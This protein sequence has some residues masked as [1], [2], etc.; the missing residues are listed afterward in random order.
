MNK[1]KVSILSTIVNLLLTIAKLFFG[2][3]INSTALIADGIHSGIDIISSF[4]TY[5][6][7]KAANKPVDKKHP[8]GHYRAESLAGLFVT[9][10]LAFSALGIIYEAVLKLFEEK[11]ETFSIGA[12][13]VVI[14]TVIVNELMARLKFHYGQKEE[15]LSLIA[16]AEHS[17]ADVLSSIGV[18]L[19]LIFGRKFPFLD[20]LVAFLIGGYILFES[21]KLGREI[22]DSLLDVANE[23]IEERIRKICQKHKIDIS[24]IK[25]RKIG[26]ANFAEIKIK[27]PLNL[28]VEDAQKITETLET[29]LLNNIPELKQIVISIE[30][31]QAKRTII[32]PRFG[33][34]IGEME[35]FEKIGPE[36]KGKRI[37]VPL[38][39]ENKISNEFGVKK[40]LVVD[41][42]KGEI[43]LKKIV[44][45]PYFEKEAPHGARFVKAIRADKIFVKQ[46]GENA[47]RNL[48][49]FG[50]EVEN[51]SE[52]EEIEDILNKCKFLKED[53][54]EK[55]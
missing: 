48:E 53:E 28:K 40:Y 50:I 13:I 44:E 17:R 6:G 25:T 33:R 29:R 31:Y 8:Y 35:G 32:L 30:G 12:I 20:S 19:P 4:G 1:E 2:F 39:G 34:K 37:I 16:D 43:V 41:V 36:K 54:I 14:I 46:I 7:I 38:E 52:K 10:I 49:S 21:F 55:N 3:L 9:L 26:S 22:T 27:L 5:L 23:E 51:V 18:L 24:E 47:K 15:S 11:Q 45:N 42:D